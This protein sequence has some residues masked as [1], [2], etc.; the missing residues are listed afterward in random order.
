MPNPSFEE[1][2]DTLDHFVEDDVEFSQAIKNWTTP[3]LASPDLITPVFFERF[4]TPPPART[5]AMM[6]GMQCGESWSEC[7]GVKLLED[8]VP[9]RTYYFEYWI[10]RAKCI[11]PSMDADEGMNDD[12]GIL[13]SPDSI[14]ATSGKMLFA[15][16]QVPAE[17][18]T[19]V[20]D[21][22]W[23]QISGYHTPTQSYTYL[24]LGQFRQTGEEV[25][26][27]S[28]Y[29]VIDDLLVRPVDGLESLQQ[30]LAL[31]VGSII[32]LQNVQF[33]SGTTELQN[34]ESRQALKELV[35]YLQ[36]NSALRIRI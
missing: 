20:T 24:Y 15:K 26:K 21:Q 35:E 7:I 11:R 23:V 30:G 36:S 2:F 5:G 1:V 14:K 19:L 27:M 9:G 28:G 4:I 16:P 8:L 22:D 18:G 32:P 12:F 6:V 10:R 33:V 3:N 34:T 31:P 25:Q 13:L 17:A 29:F